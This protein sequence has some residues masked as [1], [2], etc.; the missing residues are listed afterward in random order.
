MQENTLL[1]LSG[2]RPHLQIQLQKEI[3]RGKKGGE[4]PFRTRKKLDKPDNFSEPEQECQEITMRFRRTIHVNQACYRF[5]F[6]D[7]YSLR[8]RRTCPSLYS[9]RFTLKRFEIRVR[10]GAVLLGFDIRVKLKANSLNSLIVKDS[11]V[12]YWEDVNRPF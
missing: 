1:I 4:V 9:L 8:Y 10:S 11:F 5:P 2:E 3:I 6:W 7:P 12:R